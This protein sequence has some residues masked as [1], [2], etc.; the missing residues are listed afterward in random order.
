M[1]GKLELEFVPMSD[2][3]Y[4]AIR[5][6]HYVAEAMRDRE[7]RQDRKYKVAS[8]GQQVHFLVRYEDELVGAISGGAAVFGTP[9]RNKFFN[10]PKL[11][12][13][14]HKDCENRPCGHDYMQAICDNTLFRLVNEEPV[15]NLGS[16]TLRLW[17]EAAAY[18]WKIIYGNTIIGFETFVDGDAP[19]GVPRDGRMYKA[20]NW[21]DLG[22]TDGRTKQH[23][24]ARGLTETREHVSTTQ[25]LIYARWAT[26]KSHR[27]T[28]DLY[29]A[30]W[31][32]DKHDL[33]CACVK[34]GGT[35]EVV[36]WRHPDPEV[37]AKKKKLRSRA[38]RAQFFGARFWLEGNVLRS[39]LAP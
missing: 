11:E 30:G 24:K 16:A 33:T 13:R 20:D 29:E 21:E 14:Y 17:R 28:P 39:T 31:D 19:G 27:I 35:S 23:T 4:V 5:D 7:D 22:L 10:F 36:V 2:P 25:K 9:A 15:K 8:H 26:S 32:C 3:D 34:C 6:G 37:R 18:T 1:L 12:A 38:G